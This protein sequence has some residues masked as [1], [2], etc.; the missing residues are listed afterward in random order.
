MKQI[1]LI[2]TLAF[3]INSYSQIDTV[4]I[5][6]YDF[7]FTHVKSSD[8]D[9]I[10]NASVNLFR[11]GKNGEIKYLL[12][13]TLDLTEGDCNSMSVEMGDYLIEDSA[14]V[15][16]SFW[17]RQGD[18]PVSPWG[19][20]IQKYSVQKN[21]NVILASSRL[22][23]ETS[24]KDWYENKGIKYLFEVAKIKKE[25]IA[26]KEYIETVEKEYNAKFVFGKDADKLL[27]DVKEKFSK[28]IELLLKD[29]NKIENSFGYKI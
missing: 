7:I 5:N 14:I 18:A 23:I 1:I 20:R 24:R 16:Y 17:C 9:D 28:R 21:G 8:T 13:H 29:W 19:A 11:Y 4:T 22:Y 10:E 2:L 25:K 15:F 26:L 6:G 27:Q 12:N 3:S